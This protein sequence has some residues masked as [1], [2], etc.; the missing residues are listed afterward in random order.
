V[1][2]VTRPAGDTKPEGVHGMIRNLKVLG[3]TVIAVFATAAVMASAASAAEFHHTGGE[4]NARTMASNAG[5]GAH[6]FTA[7]LIGS[8]SCNTATFTGTAFLPSTSP[9][10]EVSPSYSG[11]T[12]LGISNVEV[13]MEGCTYEFYVEG[14][15]FKGKVVIKCPAGK[16]INFTASGC[17]VEVGPQ[18]VNSASYTNLENET[19]KV[20]SNVTG[21]TYTGSLTCPGA[22]GTH[23]DGTYT[24]SAIATAETEFGE[25][26]G[27]FVG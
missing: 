3:I 16:K 20:S 5:Q 9:T 17:K 10:V 15:P 27:A 7:G 19:V 8:I 18:T 6:V 13:K 24:G 14:P 26:V 22:T 21:I 12:F 25:T 1:D 23:S 2:S 4:E 11:C